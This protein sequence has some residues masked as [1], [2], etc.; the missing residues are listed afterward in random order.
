MR[1]YVFITNDKQHIDEA[2][3]TAQI[4]GGTVL[5][6]NELMAGPSV[7]APYVF[8]TW[9]MFPMTEAEIA[10]KLSHVKAVFYAAGTVQYFA[11]PF[12]HSGIRVFS[13]WAANGIP[14][15]EFTAAQIILAN[16]GY[17]QLHQRYRQGWPEAVAYAD[18][19]P[20]N[21]DVCVG[22]LG[23]GVIGRAVIGFLKP[24]RITIKVFD[25]FLSEAEA[26]VLGVEK[27]S[28]EDIFENCHTISNHLANND[29][30]KEILTGAHFASMKDNAT[31]INTG[32]GAQVMVNGLM[33]ALR[34]K[35][36]RTALLDVTDPD[37][38]LPSS[39][40]LWSLSNVFITPHRAGSTTGEIKRMG[41]FMFEAYEQ[42][43]RGEAA[44]YEITL[45]MLETMA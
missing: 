21:Y 27:T 32:R 42:V 3:T 2:F 40:P 14:V 23:A 6:R 28:L 19:F 12:L 43:K 9:G 44:P 7:D 10:E 31:F 25:P 11:R 1:D 35:S 18:T 8:S 17:F 22:L 41:A 33:E 26:S 15:A 34:D 29:R 5:N 16:K 39:H 20:G 4:G 36:G 45:S 30:T 13:A 38:P 37:E 24:Y